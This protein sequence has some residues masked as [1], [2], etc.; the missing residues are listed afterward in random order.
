MGGSKSLRDVTNHNTSLILDVTPK[1][2]N[3]LS[4]AAYV[5][6]T[7]CKDG[8]EMEGRCLSPPKHSFNIP[9]IRNKSLSVYEQWFCSRSSEPT[10]P[11]QRSNSY[12]NCCILFFSHDKRVRFLCPLQNSLEN[13]HCWWSR[14]MEIP[15][16]ELKLSSKS[17]N[18]TR[19]ANG[20]ICRSEQD[21]T[22]WC[23]VSFAGL[24]DSIPDVV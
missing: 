18:L 13:L 5:P 2:T 6:R 9:V 20:K 12:N 16:H 1:E 22:N 23:H 10:A 8:R 24:F 15:T 19:K 4:V 3:L 21:A 11:S 17:L 14:I 7:S